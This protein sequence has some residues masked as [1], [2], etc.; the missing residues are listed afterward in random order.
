MFFNTISNNIAIAFE[1]LRRMDE[2]PAVFEQ[3]TLSEF[4]ISSSTTLMTFTIS[5]FDGT[6]L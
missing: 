5:N 3:L 4:K 6:E 2:E 1:K